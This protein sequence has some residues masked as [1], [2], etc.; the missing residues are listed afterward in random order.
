MVQQLLLPGVNLDGMNLMALR[1]VGCRRLFAQRLQR[2]L[3]LQRRVN[4]PSAPSSSSA[5]SY[6]IRSRLLPTIPLVPK[7]GPLSGQTTP[8]APP[9]PPTTRQ[10]SDRETAHQSVGQAFVTRYPRPPAFPPN[11][12]PLLE[13][14]RPRPWPNC[15]DPPK[16]KTASNVPRPHPARGL[17]HRCGTAVLPCRADGAKLAG[18]GRVV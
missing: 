18:L 12:L 8:Q 7:S 11:P 10:L 2:D 6:P 15:S 17:R 5:P 16:A 3:R 1:Q 9:P 14:T 13:A 4:L